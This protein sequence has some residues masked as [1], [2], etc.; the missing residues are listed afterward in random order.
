M[1]YK[2]PLNNKSLKIRTVLD[3]L[4]CMT[5]FSKLAPR[6]RDVFG[7]YINVY[8]KYKKL[9][10]DNDKIFERMFGK[11]GEGGDGYDVTKYLSDY[12]STPK[13]PVSMDIIRNYT[14]KLRKKKFIINNIIPDK[15]L[16]LF[17][18]INDDV[19]GKEIT[20]VFEIKK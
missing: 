12:L 16:N 3:I 2:I 13:K 5:P 7:E 1:R 6:E 15:F 20:F 8:F 18:E 14:T 19:T 17:E 9:G 4:G 10:L 11:K